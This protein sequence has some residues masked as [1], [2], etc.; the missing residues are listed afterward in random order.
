VSAAKKTAEVQPEGAAES[1]E[2][3]MVR[4]SRGAKAGD[5]RAVDAK[6]AADLVRAGLAKYAS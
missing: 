6:R 4:A 2:V 1:V 5:E 3:V